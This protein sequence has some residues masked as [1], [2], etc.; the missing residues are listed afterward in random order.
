MVH[1][2]R[3]RLAAF[4]IFFMRSPSVLAHVCVPRELQGGSRSCLGPRCTSVAPCAV[5]GGSGRVAQPATCGSPTKREQAR[6]QVGAAAAG[7]HRDAG[8]VG[9]RVQAVVVEGGR[10]IRSRRRAGTSAQR[11]NSWSAP[12]G[13]PADRPGTGGSL[14]SS[15]AHRNRDA[16]PASDAGT[17]PPRPAPPVQRQLPSP[18]SRLRKPPAQKRR[19]TGWTGLSGRVPGVAKPFTYPGTRKPSAGQGRAGQGRVGQGR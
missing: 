7:K 10:F 3:H 8:A 15:A 13:V 2:G 16:S 18:L 14:R 1:L 9:A 5:S 6:G 4:S 19:V 17:V 12:P 11:R